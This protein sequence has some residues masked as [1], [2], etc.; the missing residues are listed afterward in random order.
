MAPRMPAEHGDFRRRQITTAAWEC[1]AEKGYR[2]T[3]MRDIARR[4]N[5]STGVIYRYFKNKDEILEAVNR[6]GQENTAR[7]FDLAAGKKTT[8]EAIA[9][10][11]RIY[12]EELSEDDRRQNARA[13]I[14]LWAEA[15]KREQ[16]RDICTSQQGPVLDR[17]TGL[18]HRGIAGGEFRTSVDSKAFA[19]FILALIRGLQVQSVLFADLD[20]PAY[21]EEVQRILLQNIWRDDGHA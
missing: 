5:T 15:L 18:I 6:C 10:I 20:T 8:R 1:F 7:F 17:M 13:A 3:T 12:S 16:Y 2:E 14:M 4:M 11:F 21:Y 9:E 19:S